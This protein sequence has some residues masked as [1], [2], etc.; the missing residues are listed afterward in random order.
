MRPRLSLGSSPCRFIPFVV[1]P[2]YNLSADIHRHELHVLFWSRILHDRQLT[3]IHSFLTCFFGV[4]KSYKPHPPPPCCWDGTVASERMN[5]NLKLDWERTH[6]VKQFHHG[7]SYFSLHQES[8]RNCYHFRQGTSWSWETSPHSMT[9][10]PCYTK[11]VLQFNVNDKCFNLISITSNRWIVYLCLHVLTI[12]Y[13]VNSV[14]MSAY[15][16]GHKRRMW[17]TDHD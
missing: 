9:S 15:T 12:F 14:S 8:N 17:W 6:R 3:S 11:C 10:Y 7:G 4:C 16:G 2:G 5:Q 13:Q 1:V